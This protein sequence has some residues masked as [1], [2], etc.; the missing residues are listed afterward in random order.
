MG[1]GPGAAALF[2]LEICCF[3][4]E[5]EVLQ[6]PQKGCPLPA[7]ALVPTG[8]Q[9]HQRWGGGSWGMK[10]ARGIFNSSKL[11]LSSPETEVQS[12]P[13]AT[14][15]AG[16]RLPGQ[17]PRATGE[18]ARVCGAGAH[19]SS[20]SS[21]LESSSPAEVQPSAFGSPYLSPRASF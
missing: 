13:W 12:S 21:S 20:C 11:S 19:A 2:G 18:L 10:V 14:A 6:R 15:P 8:Q 7:P 4:N 16:H 17:S 9:E 1:R 3:Q 5:R